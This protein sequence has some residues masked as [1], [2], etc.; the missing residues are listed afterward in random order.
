MTLTK[1]TAPLLLASLFTVV[2]LSGCNQKSEPPTNGQVATEASL[3]DC[4]SASIKN[5]LVRVLSVQTSQDVN[6]QIVHYRDANKIN[7]PELVQQRLS[8]LNL[9]FQNISADG[10]TCQAEM[11]ITLPVNDITAADRYYTSIDAPLS[12]EL[13]SKQSLNLDEYHRIISPIRYTANS[14]EATLLD[15]PNALTVVANIMTA[16]AYSQHTKPQPT[17]TYSPSPATSSVSYD[18]TATTTQST[19]EPNNQTEIIS[20]NTNHTANTSNST[21]STSTASTNPN[22]SSTS[23]TNNTSDS[24]SN[25]TSNKSTTKN[26]TQSTKDPKNPGNKPTLVIKETTKITPIT[27]TES[28]TN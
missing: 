24:T 6:E 15:H 9:D 1:N 23:T 26:T 20:T 16:S 14:G 10:D 25:S 28:I 21:P 7:L 3:A 5:S 12:S 8:E 13:A 2:A 22:S 4:D 17:S 27:P 18:T 11:V 19:N